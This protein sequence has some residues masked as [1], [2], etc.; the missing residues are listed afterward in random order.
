MDRQATKRPHACNGT[1][2]GKYTAIRPSMISVLSCR[3]ERIRIPWCYR[4]WCQW[5]TTA[6]KRCLRQI[7]TPKSVRFGES[8][9]DVTSRS[10]SVTARHVRSAAS[11]RSTRSANLLTRIV[12]GLHQNPSAI[13]FCHSAVH[14]RCCKSGCGSERYQQMHD[15]ARC[16]KPKCTTFDEQAATEPVRWMSPNTAYMQIWTG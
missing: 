5:R 3:E 16:H 2:E 15:A 10:N 8:W 14:F 13:L 11:N 1:N 6:D 4:N 12:N 7:W 9:R